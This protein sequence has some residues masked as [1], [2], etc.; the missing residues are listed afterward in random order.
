MPAFNANTTVTWLGFQVMD[1]GTEEDFAGS[2]TGTACIKRTVVCKWTDRVALHQALLGGGALVG[3]VVVFTAPYHHPVY[4]WMYA[5]HVHIEGVVGQSGLTSDVNG[6]IAYDYARLTVEFQQ[7]D[8]DYGNDQIDFS[9]AVVTAPEGAFKWQD[10]TPL[11]SS[12]R[13]GLVRARTH[14]TRTKN[15]VTSLP[16]STIISLIGKVNNNTF[17]GAAAEAVLFVGARSQRNFTATGT[18]NWSYA[19]SFSIDPYG[20]NFFLRGS[21][22]AYERIVNAQNTSVGPYLLGNLTGVGVGS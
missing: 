17:F 15:N 4:T 8:T 11:L 22:A 13:P 2:N 14:F 5:T 12:E 1:E 10:G 18:P 3:G 20:W 6:W 16:V 21:T 7:V 19:A 9:G